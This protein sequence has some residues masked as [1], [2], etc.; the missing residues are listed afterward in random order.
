M[1]VL[2]LISASLFVE[3]KHVHVKVITKIYMLASILNDEVQLSVHILIRLI[4]CRNLEFK[5]PT[6]LIV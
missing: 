3:R 2:V 4:Y 5:R 6:L 1:C